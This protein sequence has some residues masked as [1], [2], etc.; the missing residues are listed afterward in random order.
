MF[1]N[2]LLCKQSS[3]EELPEKNSSVSIHERNIQ[4]LAADVYKISKVCHLLR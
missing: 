2:N 3:F 4:I 1:K